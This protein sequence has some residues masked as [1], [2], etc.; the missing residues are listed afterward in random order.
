MDDSS[1]DFAVPQSAPPEPAALVL[2]A[3]VL[4]WK[5]PVAGETASTK[6]PVDVLR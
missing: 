1:N 3:M 2:L 4:N 5:K 6:K